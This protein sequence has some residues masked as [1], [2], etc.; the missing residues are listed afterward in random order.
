MTR[1][2]YS[3]E[4]M[5][6]PNNTIRSA[7]NY[8]T[9]ELS[10]LYDKSEL[11][12]LL[13]LTFLHYFGFTKLDFMTNDKK[14]LSESDLLKIIYAV[15]GLKKNKPLA[16]ILG[17]WEFYGISLKVNEHT[18]IPRPETEELIQLIINENKHQKSIKILD[19]G[20]GSGCIALALKKHLPQATVTAW[21]ISEEAL[22]IAKEN[23]IKNSLAISFHQIDIL[24]DKHTNSSEKFDV[25]VSNP[26]YIT[27]AEKSLMQENV[28]N[29]EPHLALFVEDNNPFLFYETIS[30]F[31]LQHLSAKGKLYFELNEK[32]GKEVKHL[33]S[34][35][36]FNEVEI[37]QDINGK[38]RIIKC[39]I[40]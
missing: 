38:E 37:V 1:K 6:I 10:N 17:E 19:I 11:Q 21:D 13:H 16:Y 35:K 25:I 8:F 9:S 20:T 33:L 12:Q 7:A 24:S 30:D 5:K 2:I 40:K 14:L 18:L 28:L 36:E 4:I 39:S 31:A 29:Y 23:A 32:Y 27:H 26:P 3:F 15:K 34:S 22:K